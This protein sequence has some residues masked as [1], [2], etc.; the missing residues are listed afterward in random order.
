MRFIPALVAAL[1]LSALALATDCPTSYNTGYIRVVAGDP[2]AGQYLSRNLFR[3]NN[4][5]LMTTNSTSDAL[6]VR[7][8]RNVNP[9]PLA[10]LNTASPD[11]PFLGV[12]MAEAKPTVGAG[13]F[14]YAAVT[15]IS[16]PSVL[17]VKSPYNFGGLS[18][19]LWFIGNHNE[20]VFN[21]DHTDGV[22]YRLRHSVEI[23][24]IRVYDVVNLAAYSAHWYPNDATAQVEA[25]LVFE[26]VGF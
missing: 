3:A 24:T 8:D 6:R 5:V 18:K 23:S 21:W 22:V 16:D 17:P 19:G 7:I 15:Y 14:S 12:T 20:L 1:S 10:A 2:R 4:T 25:T 9:T 13:S 26:P 11:F